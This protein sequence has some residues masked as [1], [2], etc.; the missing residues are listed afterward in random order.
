MSAGRGPRP[1]RRAHRRAAPSASSASRASTCCCSTWPST[2]AGEQGRLGTWAPAAS[3]GSTS[4]QRRGSARPTPCS[5][6]GTAAP[7][8]A[9]TWSSASS[10]PTAAQ[11]TAEMVDGPRGRPPAHARLPRHGLRPRWTSTPSWPGGPKVA[12]V[13]ELAHTNVPGSRNAKRWQDVEELLDAGID[14][15]TTVNIQ[16]L[17]SVN[18]VVEKITGVPQRETV[19]DAVVRAADQ[20]EL[21]DMTAE[22]LRRRLAHGNVYAPEK[23]DAAL[24]NYFR[25][26]NL[27]ALR[28]LAL[29]WTADRVD[30]ALQ[31]YR[32]AARH[33]RH[34]GGPRA[35]RRRPHRR[36]RGRDPDPPRGPDRRPVQPAATCSPST[37]PAPTGCRRQPGALAAPAAARRVARRHLPPGARRRR[38]RGAARLRPRRERHPARARRQP[39]A[40]PRPGCS[41]RASPAHT[42]PRSPATST[43]TSSPTATTG[44]GLSAARTG[45]AA[46]A[47]AASCAASP[48]PSLLPPLLTLA[49]VPVPRRRSTWSATCCSSCSSRSSWR[50]SAG[51]RRPCSPPSPGSLL[52]NYFFTPPLHTLTI[53]ETNNALALLRL[54][55]WW[56]RWSARSSTSPP[57][58]PGRPPGPPPRRA[59]WPT[60]PAAC[61][62]GEDAL[63]QLLEQ[64]PGDLRA[65]L[66][67]PA[68]A[69][70]RRLGVRWPAPGPAVRPTR[71]TPTPRCPPASGSSL[72]LRGGL[73]EAEDQ[74]L[75]GAFAAQA[76]VVARPHPAQRGRRRGRRPSPRPTR[77][78]PRC[79]PRSA[80]TCAPRWPRPRR[81]CPA[82]S[83]ATSTWP[84]RTGASCCQAADESL[85]RL[86]GAGRQPARH[87]PA[88]GRRPVDR[89]SSRPRSTRSWPAALDDLGRRRAAR[90]RRRR[91]RT[92]RWSWPTPDCSSGC[93]PTSVANALRYSPGRP[94][95]APDLQPARRPG[96]APGHRPR[97]RASRPTTGTGSSCPSSG[98]ATPTT[99]PASA[100]AWPCPAA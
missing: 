79:S 50:S 28:E 93:W 98:S 7:S 94:A 34:L 19:P 9:P 33:H 3:S 32:D 83:A 44:R 91:R 87:E 78:A 27:T 21:V 52:L 13:D 36:T 40:A 24:S 61:C 47:P 85:D 59:P 70:R 10:R 35:G 6:R 67:H 56:R 71:A 17:E 5:A 15:I 16:H 2:E 25:V 60:S 45:A 8:A 55:R 41:A 90:P 82:C 92:S 74:R 77:C 26:G 22:A 68:R 76:A 58:A 4:A 37:S 86:A 96:R 42:D 39:P 20:I 38:A 46:S 1:G 29:L 97:A 43:S 18:D 30:D 23:V 14:V 100:S 75:I 81:R 72:A 31:Q 95:A 84:P 62:G 66:G 51:W 88:A 48:S 89:A 80:T 69:R 63:P 65:H 11:H 57:G 12:L 49:L 54:R 53:S 99:P 64:R 73:L